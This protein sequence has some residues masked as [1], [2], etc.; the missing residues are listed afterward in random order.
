MLIFSLN[1]N[2]DNIK[3]CCRNLEAACKWLYCM[4]LLTLYSPFLVNT[5]SGW[6]ICKK[7]KK[8][9]ARARKRTNNQTLV[10][11]HLSFIF[12]FPLPQSDLFIG[13]PRGNVIK[14]QIYNKFHSW[15]LLFRKRNAS[16]KV[17]FSTFS[18]TKKLPKITILY[19]WYN[20]HIV[21]FFHECC[22]SSLIF[23]TLDLCATRFS[24][25][26]V[27]GAPPEPCRLHLLKF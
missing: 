20:S 15:L 16:N 17:M 9:N 4:C 19:Y 10:I 14:I 3:H 2:K 27:T 26:I 7:K 23:L 22:V 18:D 12:I 11:F 6:E 13:L 24:V 25:D 8:K 5:H 21:G 1:G